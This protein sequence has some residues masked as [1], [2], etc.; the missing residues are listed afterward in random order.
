MNVEDSLRKALRREAAPPDFAANVLAATAR[1]KPWRLLA[2]AAAIAIAITPPA[3]N[4]Y[5]RRR[6]IEARD[7]L[8]RAFSIT[9]TQLERVREKLNKNTRNLL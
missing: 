3:V 7:Q 9:Q 4:D 6:A 1:K 8:V 2:I 5:H